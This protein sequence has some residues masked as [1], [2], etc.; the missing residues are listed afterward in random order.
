MRNEACLVGADHLALASHT[1]CSQDIVTRAHDI[2]DFGLVE[3]RDYA[4]GGRLQFV[5]KDDEA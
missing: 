2:A 4:C 5:L 3:L 1:D